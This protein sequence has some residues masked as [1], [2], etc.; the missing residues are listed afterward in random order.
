MTTEQ[1]RD[2]VAR[3]TYIHRFVK[4]ICSVNCKAII[5]MKRYGHQEVKGYI[6]VYMELSLIT[7]LAALSV[8]FHRYDELKKSYPN[9]ILR[10]RSI[11]FLPH[12]YIERRGH[13]ICTTTKEKSPESC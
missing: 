1:E 4:V 8:K 13:S 10:F 11:L 7:T 6:V 5:L 12:D 2:S 9:P 3:Q